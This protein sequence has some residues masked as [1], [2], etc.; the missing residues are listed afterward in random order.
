M[1]EEPEQPP[2][3]LKRRLRP[4]SEAAE[5]PSADEKPPVAPETPA[6]PT[7]EAKSKLR[8]KPRLAAEPKAASVKQS[9]TEQPKSAEPPSE[10]PAEEA[11]KPFR[12]KPKLAPDPEPKIE[13]AAPTSAPEASKKEDAGEDKP[14]FRLKPRLSA[15]PEDTPT[16]E[17]EPPTEEKKDEAPAPV[18]PPMVEKPTEPEVPAE[19]ATAK[20]AP[21]FKLKKKDPEPTP[22]PKATP[23]KIEGKPAAKSDA[24]SDKAM[25]PPPLVHL[26]ASDE[27]DEDGILLTDDEQEAPPANKGRRALVGLIVFIVLGLVGYFGWQQFGPG[28]SKPIVPPALTTPAA[29]SKKPATTLPGQLIEKA[30]AAIDSRLQEE[31]DRVDAAID[32]KEVPE[33]QFKRIENAPSPE[34]Q[35]EPVAEQVTTQS[36]STIAPGVTATT[37]RVMSAIEASPAFRSFVGQM[38]INGVF[39]GSP[40]RAL[41]NGRT[42]GEGALVDPSLGIYFDHVVSEKKLIVFRDSSGAIV[43]RKY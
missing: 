24:K 4:E 32:G 38:R 29:T 28:A 33:G 14:K 15:K 27:L 2:L 41:L 34:L 6:K 11:P 42:Y 40:A 12:L 39:Q 21:K 9:E 26:K 3:R 1:S 8:L 35:P 18:P 19:P 7:T 31:Q 22:G 25:P 10:K 23:P 20:A 30:Q 43:Q 16:N 36:Q 37:T 5:S 17:E 13:E